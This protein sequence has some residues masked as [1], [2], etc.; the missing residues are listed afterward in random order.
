[1]LSNIISG[2]LDYFV[3]VLFSTTGLSL[4]KRRVSYVKDIT[5]GAADDGSRVTMIFGILTTG[6]LGNHLTN[7]QAES[8]FAR[9]L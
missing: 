9:C 1:M 7:L 6:H 5:R 8:V 3:H 2:I 4:N